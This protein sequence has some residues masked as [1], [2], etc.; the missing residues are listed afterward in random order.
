MKDQK[1]FRRRLRK[2]YISSRT[3]IFYRNKHKLWLS[4][5]MDWQ[6]YNLGTFELCIRWIDFNSK[7][8]NIYD[9]TT[10]HLLLIRDIIL[11]DFLAA[12]LTTLNVNLQKKNLISKSKRSL[13]CRTFS[14]S[15]GWRN[16]PQKGPAS[17][18]HPM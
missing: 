13:G 18:K 7:Y 12:T 15:M 6:R 2:R 14:I 16:H 9:G 3:F 1:S 5:V 17:L 4:C 10:T 11:R 8:I